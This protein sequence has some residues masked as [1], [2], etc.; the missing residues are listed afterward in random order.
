MVS[1]WGIA[2]TVAVV[3]PWLSGVKLD[4]SGHLHPG[5]TGITKYLQP[6]TPFEE[7]VRTHVTLLSIRPRP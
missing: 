6:V 1:R 3:P 5:A 4:E 7:E 2:A